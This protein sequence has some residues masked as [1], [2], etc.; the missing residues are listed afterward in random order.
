MKKKKS[1]IIIVII[2]LLF[3]VISFGLILY[4]NKH[5]AFA[6]STNYGSD[7]DLGVG[8]KNIFLNF[9]DAKCSAT[10][11][12]IINEHKLEGLHDYKYL[13]NHYDAYGNSQDFIDTFISIPSAVYESSVFERDNQKN[14]TSTTWEYYIASQNSNLY[15]LNEAAVALNKTVNVVLSFENPLYNNG[16][17]LSSGYTYDYD[18]DGNNDDLST[19]INLMLY[20]QTYYWDLM[21][22]D[23]KISNLNLIG[24]YWYNES[25]QSE[26][27]EKAIK[28]FNTNVKKFNSDNSTYYKT[29]WIPYIHNGLIGDGNSPYQDSYVKGYDYGFDYVSLQSG[30]YFYTPKKSTTCSEYVN[31]YMSNNYRKCDYVIPSETCL[32]DSICKEEYQTCKSD[33][34]WKDIMKIRIPENENMNRLEFAQLEASK[35]DMGVEFEADWRV[36][37]DSAVPSDPNASSDEIYKYYLFN[38]K[39]YDLLYNFMNY[40]TKTAKWNQSYNTYYFPDLAK[41]GSSKDPKVRQI[42]DDI[43]SYSQ[44]KEV[45]NE[46]SFYDAESC[47]I[48]FN[49]NGGNGSTGAMKC[50]YPNECTLTTNGFSRTGYTFN[51]WNTKADGSG[52]SYTDNEV[53]NNSDSSKNHICYYSS[54][55]G[56]KKT[57]DL[58]AQWTINDD[59]SFA[60]DLIIDN[61]SS[62]KMIKRLKV[63]TTYGE[64]KSKIFTSGNITIKNGEDNSVLTDTDKVKTGDILEITLSKSTIQYIIS[65]LGDVSGNKSS[66]GKIIGDGVVNVGDVGQLYRYLKGKAEFE[67]YQMAAG[68]ILS[69]NII[70]VNDVARLYR[71]IKGKNET[72]EVE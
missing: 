63:N 46:L 28:A 34:F 22:K 47:N 21:K 15:E 62:Q 35:Y 27:A 49:S 53:I 6:V 29:I 19:I 10:D 18:G 51:G 16:D 14:I 3:C 69:D 65:V 30:Y 54:T 50:T 12:D 39:H 55:N 70:K 42:Y 26:N 68:D 36:A 20:R 64:L 72:L 7:K 11:T 41:Y 2:V 9:F 61:N 43:Y 8:V 58:Y 66:S 67:D 24:F 56:T 25:V 60:D 32:G 13:I 57:I 23:N 48:N 5:N 31:C 52:I 59:I 1:S 45:S 37:S 17:D 4:L 38:S 71:Y 40:G 44:G 33:V